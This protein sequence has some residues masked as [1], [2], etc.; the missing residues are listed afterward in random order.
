MYN[1]IPGDEVAQWIDSEIKVMW[2]K[3]QESGIIEGWHG[4]GNFARTTIMYNLWKSKGL[5]VHPWRS[6][7]LLGAE[8]K[9]DTLLISLQSEKPWQGILFFD[10]NRFTE[11][12]HLPLDWPRINQFPQWFSV[13]HNQS[14]TLINIDGGEK[15]NKSGDDLKKGIPLSLEGKVKWIVF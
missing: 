1:R 5:Y 14:Y 15:K 10:D 3:Q 4:D 13:N 7:L 9:G 11:N 6:D 2:A 8:Q 12:M